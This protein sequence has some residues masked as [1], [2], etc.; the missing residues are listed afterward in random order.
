[1]EN[2]TIWKTEF[3]TFLIQRNVKEIFN[4]AIRLQSNAYIT[5]SGEFFAID[6]KGSV[7]NEYQAAKYSCWGNEIKISDVHVVIE[8]ALYSLQISYFP[9]RIEITEIK[10]LKNLQPYKGDLPFNLDSAL[11]AFELT[12]WKSL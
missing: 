3:E 5:E 6:N 2:T 12:K 8:N 10:L 7:R 9:N 1:M 4:Y 11:G